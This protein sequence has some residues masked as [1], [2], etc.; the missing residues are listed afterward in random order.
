MSAVS[1]DE[2]CTFGSILKN[3]ETISFTNREEIY[4]AHFRDGI[5]INHTN[6][7]QTFKS[8]TAFCNS[9]SGTSING[10]RACKVYRDGEWQSLYALRNMVSKHHSPKGNIQVKSKPHKESSESEN[11]ADIDSDS[12]MPPKK[13]S[14]IV[15]TK[16][17]VLGPP[18]SLPCIKANIIESDEPI[19]KL[20]SVTRIILRPRV[21]NEIEYF[22]DSYG[23]RVYEKT[24]RGVGEFVGTYDEETNRINQ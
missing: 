4:Y 3:G 12:E 5:L 22:Y 18:I 17:K 16:T 13:T 21:I 8:L 9:M 10:W 15:A 24:I 14:S 11:D 6:R 7:K 23:K 2:V 1:L 20:E 19:I